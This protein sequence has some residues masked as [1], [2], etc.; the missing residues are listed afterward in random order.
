MTYLLMTRLYYM[1]LSYGAQNHYREAMRRRGWV[2][3]WQDLVSEARR[4]DRNER[5]R[6]VR[7][8]SEPT[9]TRESED[10]PTVSPGGPDRCANHMK[11]ANFSPYGFYCSECGKFYCSECGKKQTPD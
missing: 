5:A 6:E 10:R 7:G 8:P 3:D 4:R 2:P 9:S 1:C 11:V